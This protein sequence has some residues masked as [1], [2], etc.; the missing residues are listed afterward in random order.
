MRIR[1]S[2]TPLML[3][4]MA[5]VRWQDRVPSEEVLRRCDLEDIESKLRRNRLRWFGHVKR[6]GED[7][8]VGRLGRAMRM[9]VPGR[10]PVGRPKKSWRRCIEEDM[11]DLGIEEDTAENR[12][13]WRK[14]IAPTNPIEETGR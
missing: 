7:S 11:E 10:R 4:Y 12:D 5:G 1:S 14:A 6:R 13:E 3:R 2:D 9:E 8:A